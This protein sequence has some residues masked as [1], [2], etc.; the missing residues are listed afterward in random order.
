[1][2]QRQAAG[3]RDRVRGRQAHH[4]PF[5]RPPGEPRQRHGASELRDV[6]VLHQPDAR[7]DRAVGQSEEVREEGL[8]AAQASRREGRA[9]ASRQ[10]RRQAHADVRQA[11]GLYQRADQRPVQARPL[12]V[13]RSSGRPRR[14]GSSQTFAVIAG[15]VPAIS[16]RQA[17]CSPKRDP[18]D[19]P[20]G[21]NGESVPP[22]FFGGMANS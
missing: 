17:T 9:A 19:K 3:R 21:D 10:D 14:M 15:L 8:H 13:L 1:M 20:A 6:V 4:P 18:R 22:Q 2:G 16:L 7:A 5:G 11:V 12:P